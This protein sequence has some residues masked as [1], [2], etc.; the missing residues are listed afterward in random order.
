MTGRGGGAAPAALPGA[1]PGNIRRARKG[2]ALAAL[3]LG[4]LAGGPAVA[5][6]LALVLALDVSGSVDAREYDLQVEGVAAALRD[7]E[8][9]QAILADPGA[10]VELA[11][12]EWSGSRF[13][14]QIADW[15]TLDTAAAIDGVAARLS[16][17][18]RAKAPEATGIGAAMQVAAGQLGDG[19]ACWRRVLDRR[20]QEQRLALAPAGARGGN[21]RRHHRQRA[22][23]RQRPP[24]RR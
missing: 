24:A 19:P 9:R 10:P 8:V 12:F 4:L 5:C 13:Q 20:W 6:R 15:T 14:R 3:A 11:I 23:D 7:E 17:W 2:W 16:G 21:A 22:G 1:S 18:S